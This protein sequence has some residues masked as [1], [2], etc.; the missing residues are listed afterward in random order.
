MAAIPWRLANAPS[1]SL[2]VLKNTSGPI[3]T[4]PAFN[5]D[6]TA[7]A[8]S[9]S[10]SVLARS[11]C[12]CSPRSRA[13]PRRLFNVVSTLEIGRVDEKRNDARGGDQLVQQLQSPLR[14]EL[15][16]Q[17]N[18]AREIAARSAEAGDQTKLDRVAAGIED[19]WNRS[20]C[21]PCR[22]H[23]SSVRRDK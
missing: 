7:K 8:S 14:G 5:W 3:T 12:T 13:A 9:I 6:S 11:T 10:R 19:D 20:G 2:L 23:R 22:E 21:C 4:P 17:G 1:C 18:H 16:V 15:H